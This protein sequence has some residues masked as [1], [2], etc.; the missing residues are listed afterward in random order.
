VHSVVALCE[1]FWPGKGSALSQLRRT[2]QLE[3]TWR[4]SLT[5]RYVAFSRVTELGL[6]YACA[7]LGLQVSD[8]QAAALMRQYLNLSLYPDPMPALRSMPWIRGPITPSHGSPTSRR[9]SIGLRSGVP[10][11]RFSINEMAPDFGGHEGQGRVGLFLFHLDPS[12][13]K[14]L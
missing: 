2:K 5:R 3:Y 1:R 13:C 11:G 10:K 7:L 4:R 8:A 6:R 9:W 12:L 14:E